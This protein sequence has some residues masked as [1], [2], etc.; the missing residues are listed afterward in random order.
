MWDPLADGRRPG[1]ARGPVYWP[2]SVV[3]SFASLLSLSPGRVI[4]DRY[5]YAAF[6]NALP[7]GFVPPLI[8]QL[9]DGPYGGLNC[10]CNSEAMA[11]YCESHGAR[12]KGAVPGAPWPASGDY[13]RR[14]TGDFSGGTTLRQ[15][16]AV[17]RSRYR[18]ALDVRLGYPRADFWSRLDRG[19]FAI[20]QGGYSA[21]RRFP[22]IRGSDSF[23]G[24]HS[25]LIRVER[26]N[27]PAPPPSGIVYGVNR[28]IVSGGLSISSSH[29]IELP[30]NTSLYREARVG[31]SVV[32]RMSKTA[33]V[34][35]I[36]NAGQGFRAVRVATAN[37]P[38]KQTR[39]VIV[40]VAPGVGEVRLKP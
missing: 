1:I 2:E 3:N 31:S 26:G 24:N 11:L 34:P 6:T 18:L 8:P 38:D 5:T 27:S 4:G 29:V 23:T 35:Y 15:V 14:A 19:E 28:M 37:F 30:R 33:A 25:V 39:P 32:T 10:T 13:I 12:P 9:G 7:P 22:D 16:D 21:V 36:G 20:L 17:G 40:Y